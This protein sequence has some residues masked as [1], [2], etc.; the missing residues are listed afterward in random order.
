MIVDNTF[1]QIC[2]AVLC[3]ATVGLHVAKKN[4]NEVLLYALQSSAI[5]A[6]LVVSSLH[7]KS[8]S[9]LLIAIAM[10]A[11]KVIFAPIF[12]SRLIKRHQAKFSVSTYA[13][14][15]ESLFGV[16]LILL[17]AGSS[18]MAPLTNM[19]PANHGYLVLALGAMFASVLLIANRRGAL[20][21]VT[22]VLSLENSIVAFSIF[23]G[24]EQSAALQVGIIFD[25]FVWLIIAIVMVSMIYRHTGSMDVSNMKGLQD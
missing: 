22:G 7:D 4:L 2:M 14:T 5:V 17:L 12:L 20:S 9:L 15:P 8:L 23:A 3:L 16:A 10:L 13:N 6:L 1:V 11:V 19:V 21:Q 18:V 25:I 24:L